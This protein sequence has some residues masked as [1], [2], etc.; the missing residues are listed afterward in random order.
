MTDV[1]DALRVVVGKVI[2]P[3]DDSRGH[4]WRPVDGRTSQCTRCYACANDDD[5]RATAIA[6][7]EKET[8]KCP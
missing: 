2:E 7:G 8:N 6:G 3:C 5:F 1:S 4:F